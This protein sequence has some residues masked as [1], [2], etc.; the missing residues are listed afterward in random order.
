MTPDLRG[1]H[2]AVVA[3]ALPLGHGLAPGLQLPRPRGGVVVAEVLPE[4]L[5]ERR[6]LLERVERGFQR[7][8][9]LGLV[10][11]VRVALDGLGWGGLAPDPIRSGG[12]DRGE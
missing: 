1:S 9:Q 10:E 6:V 12:T 2:A 7:R 3:F 4:R 8:R 5:A 11:R